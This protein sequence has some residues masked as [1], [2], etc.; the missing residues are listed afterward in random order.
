MFL[1]PDAPR[2]KPSA[3]QRK[4]CKKPMEIQRVCNAGVLVTLD[5]VSILLDGLCEGLDGYLATPPALLQTLLNEPPDLLAFTHS[6]PDHCSSAL[7]LPYKV[8]KLRPIFGPES[9]PDEKV[10]VGEVTVTAVET[11][12]LGKNE[13]GLIHH[14]FVIEG[15]KCIWF[16]GD[17]AP[18]EMK[19]LASFPRPD[20]LIAP[21]AYA[22]TPAAWETTRRLCSGAVVILHLPEKE[23]D[24]YGLWQQVKLVTDGGNRPFIP[25]IGESVRC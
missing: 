25:E 24:T 5:G 17:A 7:L 23:K 6:H 11:R 3:E 20:V 1:P 9:F 14:S 13:P 2:K 12:H 16:M 21:Y 22:N 10:R 18:T 15:S 19:K 8:Q 4:A